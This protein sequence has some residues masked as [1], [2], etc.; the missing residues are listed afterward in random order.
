[1]IDEL[2]QELL[3]AYVVDD[4]GAADAERVSSE[5]AADPEVRDFV[6]QME[7]AFA[8]VALGLPPIQAPAGLAQRIVASEHAS[9]RSHGPVARS[10]IVWFA[11]PW[12]L[13]ASFA[14]ASAV[15][16][17]QRTTLHKRITDAGR[18]LLVLKQENA[19]LESDL[20]SLQKRNA[21]AEVKITMLKAQVAAFESATAVVVWD[22]EQ[23]NGI[24]QLEKLP[25]AGPGKDYQLW[26][27]DPKN[28]QPVSA[29][30]LTVANNG[31]IRTSFW[32]HGPI[33]SASAFAISLEKAGGAP[34]PEGQIILV[35]K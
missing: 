10:N 16:S 20:A 13:A 31:P 7:D 14:V 27:I 34:K 5:I 12:A 32:P 19:H 8:S 35:G 4:L 21:L 29:G 25:P 28:P 15:L 22:R 2:K 23:K 9:R 3:V 33:E 26:V 11:I 18:E 30:V 17:L 6:R 1:M 24:L